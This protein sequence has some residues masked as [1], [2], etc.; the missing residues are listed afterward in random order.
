MLEAV[1]VSKSFIHHQALSEV[2]ITVKEGEIFGLLGPNGAGKTTLIRI[3]NQ[4]TA[5]DTGTV[6]INREKLRPEHIQIIG[7]LPEER[8][9]YKKMTVGEQALY[10]A[11]LKGL[12]VSEA[13][14][15]VKYWFDRFDI[16]SWWNKKVEELSKGMAQKIQFIT[17]VIH[18]PK[19]II[20]D[21]PFSGFD[22]INAAVIRK[23]IMHLKDNGATIMLSTHN[24]GSVEEICDS[25]ALINKSKKVLGGNV[26][27]VKRDF[28][29]NAYDIT[30]RNNNALSLPEFATELQAEAT[31]EGFYSK[32]IKLQDGHSLNALL[33]TILPQAEII[34]ATE[35]LPS[36]N[37][38]FI[39]V[40]NKN[41]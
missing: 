16:Q 39:D 3:I 38:I 32:R 11:R 27:E 41:A 14:A 25:F 18:Q 8:G 34:S 22:P 19:L 15:Q 36:M 30:L 37:D 2:N 5:P 4:I 23:E 24:M 29:P 26:M 1:D 28:A 6:T 21:E 31:K 17:T 10:L 7:Y 33:Q 9:L 20:L 12:S 35:V 40:V 13:K